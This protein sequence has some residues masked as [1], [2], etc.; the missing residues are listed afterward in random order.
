MPRRMLARRRLRVLVVVPLLVHPVVQGAMGG[1]QR[2]PHP[3]VN[4]ILGAG[5]HGVQVSD[6]AFDLVEDG[7]RV[8][9]GQQ[10]APST[11]TITGVPCAA[12]SSGLPG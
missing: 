7:D 2:Q 1:F 10:P 9:G 5:A 4:P 3:L 11:I 12:I 8:R 6:G